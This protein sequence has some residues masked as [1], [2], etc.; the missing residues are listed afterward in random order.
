[1]ESASTD[2][3]VEVVRVRVTKAYRALNVQVHSFVTSALDWVGDQRHNL[4]GLTP[5]KNTV[6]VLQEG[7]WA[8]QQVWTSSDWLSIHCFE[9]STGNKNKKKATAVPLQAWSGPESSRQLRFPDFMTAA[10][11]GGKDVSLKH[12]PPLPTGNTPGTHF[13]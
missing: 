12:R 3:K 4:A 2:K 8:Q 9:S 1:V 13:C 11:D 6:S 7:W 5:E 10:Q